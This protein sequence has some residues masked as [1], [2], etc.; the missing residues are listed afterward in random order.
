MT[1][2][3]KTDYQESIPLEVEGITPDLIRGKSLADIERLPIFHGNRQV[4]LADFFTVSGDPNDAQLH[5]AGNLASVHWIGAGMT[6]GAVVIEGSAGRHIGSRMQGGCI[7]VRGDVSDWVGAEMLGGLIQ[8]HGNAAHLVG[9]AYRGSAR[10]MTGGTILVHGNAG[11]EI[12]HTM[13]RGFIAVG[14]SIGDLAGMNML[15]GSLFVFG[16]CGIRHGAGMRRGT[17]AL[18]GNHRFAPLPTFRR[19]CRGTLQILRLIDTSLRRH[20]FPCALQLGELVIDL[21]NGDLLE[22]GRGELLLPATE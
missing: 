21:Y 11:N 15:A 13:R 7:E 1:L 14:G 17:L 2:L 19:A 3:L 22:G 16:D 6:C 18:L 10:G 5:W 4:K 20:A 8:V 12:G 9:A